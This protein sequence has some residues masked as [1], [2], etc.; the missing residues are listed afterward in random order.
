MFKL[1][2]TKRKQAWRNIVVLGFNE[3]LNSAHNTL[4]PVL[5]QF[6]NEARDTSFQYGRYICTPIAFSIGPLPYALNYSMHVATKQNELIAW[7]TSVH[8]V[9]YRPNNR[10]AF[11]VFNG[12]RIKAD[13]TYLSREGADYFSALDIDPCGFSDH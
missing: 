4:D 8:I 12:Q 9:R 6:F 7:V 5:D 2:D 11:I 10:D 3:L 1:Y 13:T